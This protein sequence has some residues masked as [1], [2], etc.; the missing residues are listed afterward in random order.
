[1]KKE[2]IEVEKEEEV[3]EEVKTKVPKFTRPEI[4]ED[5]TEQNIKD[6]ITSQK[7]EIENLGKEID[8]KNECIAHYS[9]FLK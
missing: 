4:E 8:R 3:K 1:M 7:I 5:L 6:I 2:T 9:K